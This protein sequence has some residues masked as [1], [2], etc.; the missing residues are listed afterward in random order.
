[1]KI[2]IN[3]TDQQKN[4]EDLLNEAL[5]LVPAVTGLAKKVGLGKIAKN[6]GKALGI[7]DNDE[8]E[9]EMIAKKM[10]DQMELEP[11]HIESAQLA[12][13]TKMLDDIRKLLMSI[14][15]S[16]GDAPK[17]PDE[18]PATVKASDEMDQRRTAKKVKDAK[19]RPQRYNVVDA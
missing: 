7:G 4:K 5:P 16:L 19:P 10:S 12:Q 13:H 8:K 17:D 15:S 3:K 18:E 1:M 2:K 14:N 9:A 11:M 6:L